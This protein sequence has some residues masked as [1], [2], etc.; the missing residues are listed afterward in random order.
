MQF[1]SE[2]TL[3]E[4][5]EL[6]RRAVRHTERGSAVLCRW[7]Y[8]NKPSLYFR[9]IDLYHDG[10]MEVYDKDPSGDPASP[11]NGQIQGLF[12]LAS[13]ER[14]STI[15]EPNRASQFGD[16]RLLVPVEEIMALA[17]NLYFVDYY[18]MRGMNHYVT[19]V[20]T[21]SG[22]EADQYCEP[23]LLKLDALNN[24]FLFYSHS[25]RI[26]FVSAAPG[27]IVELLY[28]ENI[29]I[30]YFCTYHGAQI[31]RNIPPIGKGRSTPGGL[32]KNSN[33]TQCNLNYSTRV[34]A[35]MPRNYGVQSSKTF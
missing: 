34:S 23:R 25:R 6:L 4:I 33:C 30:R 32:K 20:M 17:P 5:A 21:K 15:G 12:F 11:I 9:D 14:G 13:V 1:S 27:L 18:C 28:T 22:S 24:P 3:D 26:W 16:T 7:L 19:L 31:K 29:D 10:I 8:R 2:L 35:Y